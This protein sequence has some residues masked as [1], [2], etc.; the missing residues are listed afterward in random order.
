MIVKL[1]AQVLSDSVGEIL[2]RFGPSEANKT[3]QFCIKMDKFF[4]CCN[5]RNTKEHIHKR[6]PFLKPYKII[7][8]ERFEWLK[9]KTI[10][11]C[12]YD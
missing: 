9:N 1:A 3:G 2:E 5:L 7:D 10:Y 6:K 11:S 8:D 4:D 12:D